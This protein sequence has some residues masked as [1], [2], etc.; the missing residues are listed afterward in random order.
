MYGTGAAKFIVALVTDKALEN[1]KKENI[2]ISNAR[3]KILMDKPQQLSNRNGLHGGWRTC[4]MRAGA[5]PNRA[6]EDR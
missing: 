6:T 1:G 3:P 2:K 4:V 5:N